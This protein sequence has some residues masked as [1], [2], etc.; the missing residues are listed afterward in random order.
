M[1]KLSSVLVLLY[2][3]LFAQ[4]LFSQKKLLRHFESKIAYEFGNSF[5]IINNEYCRDSAIKIAPDYFKFPYKTRKIL[6]YGPT[7]RFTI[8]IK[9]EKLLAYSNTTNSDSFL[10]HG[11]LIDSSIIAKKL[12][13]LHTL[14][15]KVSK[16]HQILQEWRNV[17]LLKDKSNPFLKK[18]YSIQFDSLSIGEHLMISLRNSTQKNGLINFEFERVDPKPLRPFLASISF[19]SSAYH[20]FTH[21]VEKELNNKRE[22]T[23]SIDSF[24]RYWPAKRDIMLQNVH[25]FDHSKLAL[26]FRK[27]S[28]DYPDASLEFSLA[29]SPIIDTVWQNSIHILFIPELEAD[30]HYTLLVRYKTNPGF[31]QK[32]SF[33]TDPLWYQTGLSK[34]LFVSLLIIM[35]LSFSLFAYRS[36]IRILRKKRAQLSLEIKSIRS[37]LNPH[38]VFNAL[39]SIQGLINK[40]EISA[41]NHYLTEFSTL[42]RES[43]RNNDKEMVPLITEISLLETYLKLEQLRFHFQYKITIDESINQ[44]AIEIPSLLLQPL[45]E[46][47]IKHGTPLLQERG[48][49]TIQF[50]T[51]GRT[52]RILISDNGSGFNGEVSEKGLGL[53]LTRDRIQLLNQTFKKQQIRIEFKPVLN[54]GTTVHLSFENWL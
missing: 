11:F 20:L 10:L 23:E 54:N 15:L 42:L 29:T 37:Q 3:F 21:F 34:V 27:P 1:K 50:T 18:G 30:K 25:L 46:N 38:F 28:P 17:T 33:Y 2:I 19:D 53:K 8:G 4:Q 52:L 48:I 40:N 7:L 13:E 41:A 24:Y 6:L 31:V 51:I 44:N 47:A 35:L 14:Q 49:I 12:F 32:Y 9:K 45:V 5:I 43:L 26:Y 36:R 16:N 22:K 39:S